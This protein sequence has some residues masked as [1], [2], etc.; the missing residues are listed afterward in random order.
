[1]A[2]APPSVSLDEQIAGVTGMVELQQRHVQRLTGSTV[3]CSAEIARLGLLE[4][5]LATLSGL[6]LTD[7]PAV[8]QPSTCNA[9]QTAGVSL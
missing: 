4:S 8:Q 9:A 7:A 6:Q 3:P 2:V 5:V 1:M